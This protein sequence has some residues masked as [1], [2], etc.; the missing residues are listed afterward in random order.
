MAKQLQQTMVVS[1]YCNPKFNTVNPRPENP[2]LMYK[3][4]K[5]INT[6]A[7]TIGERLTPTQVQVFIDGGVSVTV[8]PVK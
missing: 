1:Q 3:V 8:Q 4:E 6:L 5:T 2:E 7:A